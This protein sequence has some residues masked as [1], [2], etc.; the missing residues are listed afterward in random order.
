MLWI[1]YD[2]IAPGSIGVMNKDGHM[3]GWL[4]IEDW[5]KTGKRYDVQAILNG[6]KED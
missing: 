5:H 6:L 1:D 2:G 3:Y 4:K